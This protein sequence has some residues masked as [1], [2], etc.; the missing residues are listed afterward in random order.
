MVSIPV[1]EGLPSA[2][3]QSP[4]WL[5]YFAATF[6]KKIPMHAPLYDVNGR[7]TLSWVEALQSYQPP[8]NTPIIDTYGRISWTWLNFMTQLA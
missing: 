5:N 4:V 7:L 8:L 2:L 6:G 3:S 1:A